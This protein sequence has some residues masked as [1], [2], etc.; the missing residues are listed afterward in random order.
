MREGWDAEAQ[1]WIRFARTHGH[2][3]VYETVNAPA[4]SHPAG[5]LALVGDAAALPFGGETFD[6]VVAH[7]SLQD[8][9]DMPGAI[10]EAARVLT[11]SPFTASTAR[12][13]LT[14]ARSSGPAC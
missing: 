14:P 8:V 1:N 7:L 5:I 11:P 4:L 9:D 3:S 10:A 2:D 12:S 13:R 6:L